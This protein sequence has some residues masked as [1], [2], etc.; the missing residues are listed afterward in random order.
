[1]ENDIENSTKCG[2]CNDNT[3]DNHS[4]AQSKSPTCHH[5]IKIM[6]YNK[7]KEERLL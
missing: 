2:D 1:M 5:K 6:K 7:E 3:L 4:F